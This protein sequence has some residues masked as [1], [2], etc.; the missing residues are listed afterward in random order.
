MQAAGDGPM[1]RGVRRLW[2]LWLWPLLWHACV[3]ASAPADG[4]LLDE[5]RFSGN[6]VTRESVM[7]QELSVRE[8]EPYTAELIEKSRQSLMNLGLFKSVEATLLQEQ[9]RNVL[10]FAVDE[11]F[12]ILPLP[13]LD[14]RPDFLADE[15]ATN[16]S[17]GGELRLDNLFGLNQRLKISYEEKKYVDDLEPPSSKLV[18][19]YVYPRI[20]GTPFYLEL[21]GERKRV[22]SDLYEGETLVA[23]A[24]REVN[25]GSFFLSRWLNR[26]GISE[27]WRAGSGL[28][29]STTE[30]LG[31]LPPGHEPDR[32][33]IALLGRIGYYMVDVHPY[34]RDGHEFVYA[35]ELARPEWSSD[36]EYMRNTFA[37]R[38]YRPLEG[39]NANFNSQF[40]LGLAFGDEQ[41]YSLGG[42]DTLRGY[43]QGFAEGN[44]LLQGNFEYQHHLSGY[45]QMRG[46]LFLD[47]ANVWPQ[48]DEI[49]RN[50]L[51]TGI[52]VGAR[53]RVQ[54]FVDVTL[55]VDYA[56]N[57]DT[58][59]TE[60]YL[61][62]SGSF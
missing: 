47:V 4:P 45:L 21:K 30:Y 62:S 44:M 25:T 13:L 11:R 24:E 50:R 7:R 6:R 55:S 10:L 16:Y 3:A 54:S 17:Y 59:G 18:L 14:Y 60:T 39:M 58:G 57:T 12:Y 61:S 40:R 34:H 35:L 38:I 48:V 29:V 32:Q 42:S 43:E 36:L 9:G 1:G 5:I 26:Q 22:N 53:W 31:A 27:G 33:E 56:Y 28:R 49:D 37:Y 23:S 8:G 41:A 19:S 51:Y 2:L 20:V 46:V 15:T 52:G